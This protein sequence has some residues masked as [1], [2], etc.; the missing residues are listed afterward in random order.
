MFLPILWTTLV[1]VSSTQILSS[2]Q[3]SE[4]KQD[5]L[6]PI[7]QNK[8]VN[9]IVNINAQ[10]VAQELWKIIESRLNNRSDHI[11]SLKN[12]KKD[13]EDAIIPLLHS[14]RGISPSTFQVADQLDKITRRALIRDTPDI[15]MLDEEIMTRDIVAD[16]MAS[17]KVVL[18]KGN[19]SKTDKKNKSKTDNRNNKKDKPGRRMLQQSVTTAMSDDNKQNDYVNVRIKMH[20]KD[21]LDALSEKLISLLSE[22]LTA[23]NESNE[24]QSNGPNSNI[25]RSLEHDI[26]QLLRPKKLKHRRKNKNQNENANINENINA[27]INADRYHRRSFGGGDPHLSKAHNQNMNSNINFN[28]NLNRNRDDIFD[29]SDEE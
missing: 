2:E 16:M 19:Q 22:H 24:I 6:G 29:F 5:N 28:S 21:I 23:S 11:T 10:N 27:N 14:R 7:F 17:L 18:S 8:N 1:V 13:L 25:R 9:V 4:E 20:R 12:I 15:N 26:Q 3:T